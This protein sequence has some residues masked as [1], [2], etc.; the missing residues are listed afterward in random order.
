MVEVKGIKELL[1]EIKDEKLQK[2]LL[3]IYED[4]KEELQNKPAAT[5]HH[6]LEAGGFGR[7]VKEV[8]NIALDL[9][10]KE[11]DEYGCSRDDV[12]VSAFVHD[13]NKLDLYTEAAEWQKIKYQQKFVKIER[14][15]VNE[16]ARTVNLCAEYGLFMSDLILN[17]ITLHHGNWSVDSSSPHGYI[18]TRDFT[19][20]AILLH[21]ADLI[22]SQVFGR[23]KKVSL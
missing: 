5:K 16:T 1:S 18:E 19:G 11:P 22:S 6:H 2:L 3:S 13:F 12:I 17:A 10:D 15:R 20:L 8:M 7:H 23:P 14:I 4:I 21:A 9:Y